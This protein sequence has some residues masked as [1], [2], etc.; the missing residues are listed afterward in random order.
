[1]IFLPWLLP[2]MN[3]CVLM[4]TSDNV[5]MNIIPQIVNFAI[6]FFFK[7]FSTPYGQVNCIGFVCLLF[8]FTR[9]ATCCKGIP[10]FFFTAIFQNYLTWT[11]IRQPQCFAI[12]I[13]T[14]YVNLMLIL[15]FRKQFAW[16]SKLEGGTW[17]ENF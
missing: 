10:R 11:W 16:S 6:L 5:I 14:L 13:L 3:N 7:I 9:G 15:V 2:W 8:F 1:M 4:T 12:K 17:Q